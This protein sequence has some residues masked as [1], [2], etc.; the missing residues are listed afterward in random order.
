MAHIVFADRT[1]RYDGRDLERRPLGGTESS[2]I[3]C[4]REL[5]KRGHKVEVYSNCDGPVL[6]QGVAWRP[7]TEGRPERCDLYIACHQ[8]DLLGFV[9]RPGRRSLW[10]LWPVSQLRHYKKL[11][12]SWWYRPIPVLTS[13]YQAQTY[14]GLLPKRDPH[15]VLPHGLPE[16]VRGSPPLKTAPAPTAI[17]V[18]NPQRNLRRLVEIWASSILP[19][20]PEATFHV[21]GVNGLAPDEDAWAVWAGRMLPQGMSDEVKRSVRIF[22]PQSREQLVQAM[23]GARVLLY[24][25]HKA[26][27][28]CIGVA[29]AQALGVPAVV[30]PVT[31][32]PE[33][34][35]DNV[36]G[37]VRGDETEFANAAVALL[38]DDQLWRHQHEAAIR[39]QQGISWSEHAG[40]L[41]SLLL[42][43]REMI[44]RSVVY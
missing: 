15:I 17:F 29:E 16:D 31:V 40:R 9:K 11:W 20:V 41:E 37:F 19:R 27:A 1:G 18:S 5:A 42:G 25:G 28:F 43:D 10:V 22:P 14:S 32:L 33:R 7:L 38:T 24:L 21:Y 34:V 2:V 3:R 8:P 35:I 4:A 44:Y 23:R 6:D 39:H 36:T 12:L 13:L 30:A 26:E